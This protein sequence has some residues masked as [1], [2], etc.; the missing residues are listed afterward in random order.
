M[1]ATSQRANLPVW[2]AR[3]MGWLGREVMATFNRTDVTNI[4]LCNYLHT[5][6][7]PVDSKRGG[8]AEVTGEGT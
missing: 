5:Q 1:T 6:L 7:R 8:S 2:L 4:F 3:V